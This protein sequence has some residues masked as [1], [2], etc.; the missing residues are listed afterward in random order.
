[1]WEEI[2]Y[3][4]TDGQR[5]TNYYIDSYQKRGWTPTQLHYNPFDR[6]LKL[7]YRFNPIEAMVNRIMPDQAYGK[8]KKR[9]PISDHHLLL[10]EKAAF[11]QCLYSPI[12]CYRWYYFEP[13]ELWIS[14]GAIDSN[15]FW[16]WEKKKFYLS[17]WHSTTTWTEFCHYLTF[18]PNFWPPL[19]SSCP[20]SYWITPNA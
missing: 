14:G 17:R 18:F 5:L 4:Q 7:V 6:N 2:A 9:T 15:N 1:M 12:S 3:G 11:H 20:C 13:L 10:R 19:P 16:K 8:S